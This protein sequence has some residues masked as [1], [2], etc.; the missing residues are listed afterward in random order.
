MGLSWN[1][2]IETTVYRILFPN[3]FWVV[4]W[5]E[6]RETRE[7]E[8]GSVFKL[9]EAHLEHTRSLSLGLWDQQCFEPAEYPGVT[10]CQLSESWR[11]WSLSLTDAM[12]PLGPA[13]PSASANSV[14]TAG[15][16]LTGRAASGWKRALLPRPPPP[17]GRPLSSPD[18]PGAHDRH[19]S[20]SGLGVR[21]KGL[22]SFHQQKLPLNCY[23][24]RSA[25][26]V[27]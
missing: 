14:R 13:R 25:E 6:W 4:N 9:A 11:F 3:T 17:K 1:T 8:R 2:P 23:R 26:H 18:I 12:W 19:S 20:P 24:S 21:F 5:K 22:T 16:H 10:Y 15:F 27:N 7:K